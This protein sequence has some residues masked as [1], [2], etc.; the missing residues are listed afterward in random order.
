MTDNTNEENVAS[1]DASM[2][3]E[4]QSLDTSPP[5]EESNHKWIGAVKN[6]AFNKGYEKGLNEIRQQQ[7]EMQQQAAMQES[8]QNQTQQTP[9]IAAMIDQRLQELQKKQSEEQQMAY[10]QQEAQRILSELQAKT[11]SAKSKYS[12]FDNKLS[13]VGY[14]EN[15]PELLHYVNSVD[16]AGDV[17]YDLASNPTKIVQV[18][19]LGHMNPELAMREIKKLS[20]SIKG[21]ETGKQ[22][23]FSPEPTSQL[24]SSNVGMDS[25]AK[26]IADFKQRYRG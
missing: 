11:E 15:V 20:D 17:M 26:T 22:T 7:A 1:K 2:D 25:G 24:K 23:Q 13:S 4:N 10:A 16:N 19:A 6:T 12:D 5:Q 14:F 3:A 9:D 21:N 18:A 8:G